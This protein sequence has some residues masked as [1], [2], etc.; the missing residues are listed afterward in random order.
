MCAFGGTRPGAAAAAAVSAIDTA[1]AASTLKDGELSAK[2]AA[3]EDEAAAFAAGGMAR[4]AD[5]AECG[6]RTLVC[7]ESSTSAATFER[8]NFFAKNELHV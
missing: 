7:A 4:G 3:A 8:R 2:G 6:G 5:A 1:N